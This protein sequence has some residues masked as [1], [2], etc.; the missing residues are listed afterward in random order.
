MHYEDVERR[1]MEVRIALYLLIDA[2]GTADRLIVIK[3]DL[4]SFTRAPS[5]R[6]GW[7]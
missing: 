3:A 7:I 5:F 1:R 4:L 6:Y 2:T